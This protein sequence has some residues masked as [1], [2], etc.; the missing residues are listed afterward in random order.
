MN[1]VCAPLLALVLAACLSPAPV[2]PA[3]IPVLPVARPPADGSIYQ[4]ATATRLFEDRKARQVGD[5]LTILLVEETAAEKKANTSTGKDTSVSLANPTLLGRPVMAGGAP[6]LAAELSGS[7]SFKGGGSSQQS[8]KLAGSIT[9]IVTQVLPNG[10]MA[11]RGS[12]DLLLNQG[13]ETISVQGLVRGSDIR[14]DNT[15]TSDRVADARIAYSGDGSVDSAG[16]MGWL[17]RFFQ[18]AIWPF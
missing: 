14:A 11:I 17:A 6:I 5:V 12:K 4:E 10:L 1:R 9:V 2:P 3:T 7:S 13:R 15:L 8:N 18:S 16:A